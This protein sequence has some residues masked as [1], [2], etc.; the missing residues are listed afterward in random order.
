[1]AWYGCR[2]TPGEKAA[3]E[4]RKADEELNAANRKRKEA[5]ASGYRC[6]TEMPR[7]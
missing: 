7:R 6:V 1:M 2:Q 5:M 3:E 4:K